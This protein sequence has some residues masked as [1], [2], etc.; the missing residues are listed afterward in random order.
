MKVLTSVCLALSLL[1]WGATFA[2]Q[3]DI[4]QQQQRQLVQP[5][6]N[7]PVWREVRK[8]AQ[9]HTTTVRGRE[10]GVL[11]QSAGQT[12]RQIRNGPV[13]FY[14]GWLVVLVVLIIAGLYFAKG[15]IK[16][17][18]R[19][20]GRLI[21]R[22][23][24]VEMVVHWST[25]ISFCILGLSGLIM[26]FGKYVVLPVIGYT[27]FAWLT[28][29]SKNLHNFIAP[30]FILSVVVMI[31][32]WLRDNLPRAYDW[33]WF[34]KSWAFFMRGEHIPSGR[35]NAGEK[36]W[37]W[38]GIVGLS[39]VVSWSGVILLFPNFDQTRAA[40]QEAWIWHAVAA[41]IYIA[42]SLGH[43]YMGTI[44]VEGAY[45]NMR[46]GYTDETWAKEH[47][48]MWLDEVKSG[49]AAAPGGAVPAGAPHMKEKS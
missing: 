19:P 28:A 42:I 7:A 21:E 45:G 46:T 40:M 34:R 37:F 23:S 15:P 47:H 13:T 31:V 43:I 30:L 10:A 38:F 27:L 20:T 4:Q 33:Q 12:W 25:A 35:F 36:G 49:K 24:T 29:L 1:V 26:L 11:V 3:T 17:H 9:E 16:L 32:I 44:G 5:G 14:G 22:F 39:I 41:L 18:E 8:E 6:N 2:Q 48:Q